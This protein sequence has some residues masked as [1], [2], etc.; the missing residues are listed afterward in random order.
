MGE[1]FG[2][3]LIEAQACGVP[4]ITTDFSACPEVGATGWHVG[5][6]RTRT[7]QESWQ[8]TPDV[9]QIVWALGEAYNT[10]DRL[11]DDAR[12]H[13]LGYDADTVVREHFLPA[14]EE[15]AARLADRPATLLPV[16]A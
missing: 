9:D 1:G 8:V 6:T 5:G 2:I 11:K 16:A 4:V 13:A 10:A 15:I 7:F 14:L 3:P 12:T